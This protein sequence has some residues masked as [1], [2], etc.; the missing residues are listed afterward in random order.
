MLAACRTCRAWF[1][2][3]VF[4]VPHGDNFDAFHAKLQSHCDVVAPSAK[5]VDA[6]APSVERLT[7]Q[8]KWEL[9]TAV[10]ECMQDVEQ[11]VA[12]QPDSCKSQEGARRSAAT[13]LAT[14]KLACIA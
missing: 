14:L 2:H 6:A 8:H 4:A 10:P 7:E 1:D 13:L 5:C 11:Q 3:V 12:L 9:L